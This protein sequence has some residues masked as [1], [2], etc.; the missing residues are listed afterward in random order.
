MGIPNKYRAVASARIATI[1]DGKR[2]V[3][4]YE[5]GERLDGIIPDD[6]TPKYT[7]YVRGFGQKRRE[8]NVS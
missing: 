1:K 8:R 4:K 6:D 3:R 7:G 5:S 2:V